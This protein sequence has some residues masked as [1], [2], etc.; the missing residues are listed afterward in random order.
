MSGQE[1][2][3]SN[4]PYYHVAHARDLSGKD[5]LLFRL[6]EILPGALSW[7]TIL[8]IVILSIYKPTW[9]AYFILAFDFYWLLKTV[10]LSFHHRYNWKRMLHN[11][12]VD[13]QDM[14]GNLKYE[15]IYHIVILPYYTESREVIEG[16]L[17]SLENTNYRK[18]RM[19][20]IL[21]AE[22]RA[23]TEA[24]QIGREMEVKYANVF[25]KIITTVHPED[26]PGEMAGKGSNI[27]YAAEQG[28]IEIL[29][30]ENIS[31]ENVL[32]SAF[33]IDT[34]VYP[35]YFLCLTWHFLTA[36]DPYKSS[37]QPIP[38]YNNNIWEANPIS[39]V[40]ALTS[41]YWQMIQQER[42]EKLATFSS[43]AVSFR[44]LFENKY[45][46]RNMVSEDS[47]IFW[48]MLMAHNGNYNVVPISYPVSM[49]ANLAESFWKT[50]RNI[51]K[52][53]RRWSWG[54]E[55]IPYVLFNFIKNKKIP[56][57]KKIRYSFVQIEGFWS[58][59]T[60]PLVILL[61]GWL[62]IILGGTAFRSTVLS[63]N[64][65][66]I[67]RNLMALAM[68]GLILSA[69]IGA[70][71]VPK[72][73]ESYRRRKS[74][75]VMMFLQWLLVPFTIII[76]GA[77]PGLDAQTRLMFGRYMGFWVTPKH[78]KGDTVDIA[79]TGQNI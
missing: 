63:Y 40:A 21:A 78:R 30:K 24:I 12:K 32:V 62:P 69:I 72:M 13:W 7:G 67:T 41:T 46:Q 19:L 47:R 58:L 79:P 73:P 25:A 75:W 77:I 23:G 8:L 34:V 27:S 43:H 3:Y 53:H 71:L 9:A 70:S 11:I 48:N 16:T 39:R 15:H 54:V 33:D 20:I 44:T 22:E 31:Y 17:K 2:N 64:L 18:D 59:A 45:W 49:D 66:L 74:R 68:A 36:E 65:P 28:R 55:N 5:K 61:L 50:M 29:D 56:L 6:L 1:Y 10:H 42:P 14:I 35:Q 57:R 52:Q 60:N 76:F 37:F 4:S 51:Y 38:L 26:L